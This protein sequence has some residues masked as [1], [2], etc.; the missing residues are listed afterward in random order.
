VLAAGTST[1][2]EAVAVARCI[3]CAAV[4]WPHRALQALPEACPA[5]VNAGE[6]R[7]HQLRLLQQHAQ[8][9]ADKRAHNRLGSPTVIAQFQ[10]RTTSPAA[11]NAAGRHEGIQQASRHVNPSRS[12]KHTLS[13][14]EGRGSQQQQGVCMFPA[15]VPLI[16]QGKPITV[17]YFQQC[18]SQGVAGIWGPR[19]HLCPTPTN[20]MAAAAPA[21]Q[22]SNLLPSQHVALMPAYD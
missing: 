22:T 3:C 14:L 5:D 11:S 20:S 10:V 18:T 2:G 7:S 17:T 16:T 1:Q 4:R 12:N 9:Q 8:Q 6:A 13:V 19:M 15:V 21:P